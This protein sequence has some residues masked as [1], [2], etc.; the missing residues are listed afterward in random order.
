MEFDIDKCAWLMLKNREKEPAEGTERPNEN[1]LRE[2]KLQEV[3]NNDE[4][5]K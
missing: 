3:V 2:E 5:T 4:D 1:V